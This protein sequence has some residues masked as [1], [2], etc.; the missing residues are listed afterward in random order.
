MRFDL[1]GQQFGDYRLLRLLGQGGFA[2][3]YLGE[4]LYLGMQVAVKVLHARLDGEDHA[5][6][7]REARLVTALIH[8]NILRVLG[9]DSADGIPYLVMDYAPNGS[10]RQCHPRGV[11]LPLKIVLSYVRQVAGALQYAHDRRLIHRDVKPENL[12]LGAQQQVMLGDFGVALLAQST[13]LQSTQGAVGTISYMAPEQI[14]GQPHRASDQYALAAVAYEW[15]S[16]GPLFQGSP[17]EV[18]AQHLAAAPAPLRPSAAALTPAVEEV[19]LRAL[20]KDPRE[21]FPS[22]LAFA[23]AL[24]AASS[25]AM[26]AP[27]SAA[28]SARPAA[29]PAAR[30]PAAASGAREA[31]GTVTRLVEGGV[32]ALYALAWSPDGQALAVAG[33]EAWVRVLRAES[34]AEVSAFA[35]H[36]D[37][38]FAVAWSPDGKR[39]ASAGADATVQV[40]TAR[41]GKPVLAYEGH[42]DYVRAVGW[43]PDGKRIASASDDTTVQVWA[44]RTGKRL[45]TYEKHGDY[46][47]AVGWS[48]DGKQI[49]SASDDGTVQV[50]SALDGEGQ[51]WFRAETGK[52]TALAWSPGCGVLALGGDDGVVQV[53]EV[54]EK[55]LR[56][57]QRGHAGAITAIAWSPDSKRIAS[58][59]PDGA[60]HLWD[61]RTG[62]RLLTHQGASAG[63]FWQSFQRAR[64]WWGSKARAGH[65]SVLEEREEEAEE[66]VAEELDSEVEAAPHEAVLALAWSPDGRRLASGGSDGT[67]HIW[68]A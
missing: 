32:G 7:L 52:I 13:G 4:H 48:P 47:R 66:A 33:A 43:S 26:R 44:A 60:V 39:A 51:G 20:A 31:P 11:Q 58:A 46:V 19:V 24:E 53:W 56:F 50:W 17:M 42:S 65:S 38:V 9:G 54:A 29:R 68:Q 36:S 22:V 62:Q 1:A 27:V 55:R 40:W 18:L 45:L 35:G 15:L 57:A 28:S 37:A 63:A 10:L 2:S 21:R 49:A 34:G 6:F 25:Q 61:A 30:A 14:Q 16:G 3:V 12:L 8:P 67:L 5:A 23:D 41:T 59:A 64:A